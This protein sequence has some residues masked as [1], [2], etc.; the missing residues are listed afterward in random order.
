MPNAELVAALRR[1]AA[2]IPLRWAC[3]VVLRG[4]RWIPGPVRRVPLLVCVG[5]AKLAAWGVLHGA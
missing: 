1:R 5:L 4:P 3:G 2:W